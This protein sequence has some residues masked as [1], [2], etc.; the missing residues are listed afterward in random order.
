MT[1][2]M[3]FVITGR[4]ARGKRVMADLEAD[5]DEDEEAVEAA[6]S[7]AKVRL[8]KLQLPPQHQCAGASLL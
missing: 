8:W 4:A 2:F 3:C 6:P 5:S 1:V 7:P